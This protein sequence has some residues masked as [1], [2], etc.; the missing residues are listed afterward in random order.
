VRHMK[1]LVTLAAALLAAPAMARGQLPPASAESLDP[2]AEAAGSRLRVY[3]VTM[4]PGD[5]IYEKFGHNAI[6]VH[7]PESPVEPAYNWGVFDFDQPNFVGRF[8]RGHMLYTLASQDVNQMIAYYVRDLNRSVTLQELAMTPEQK[9]TLRDFVEWNARPEN[10]EYRYDYFRDNC[11]TRVR[12]AIDRAMGGAL[13]A[14]L[15]SEPSGTTFRF[16]TRR[17]T[18]PEFPWYLALQ[19]GLGLPGEEP[20]TKW[21]ESFIPMRLADHLRDHQVTGGDGGPTSL[22]ASEQ[23]IHDS[24][25]PEPAEPPASSSALMAFLGL[26]VAAAI[27][28]LAWLPTRRG[29]SR[30][31]FVAAASLWSIAAGTTGVI[32]LLAWLFTDHV[33]MSRNASALLA[34]PLSLLL[35][36]ALPPA[37]W[38]PRWRRFS[39]KVAIAVAALAVVGAVTVAIPGVGQRAADVVALLLPAQLAVAWGVWRWSGEE[40][41]TLT[42]S[43]VSN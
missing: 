27:A 37:V 20:L 13:R 43:Q 3:V 19:V 18:A 26:L 4:G 6:W 28:L 42:S 5:A 33:Y 30:R 40:P 7:D 17:L 25:R 39:L 8:L 9:L 15:D 2:A 22:V 16:H 21:E 34:S 29:G 23:V 36:A 35:A 31:G 1:L 10:A 32:L 11:S 38:S 24:G 41:S 12:D 14:R